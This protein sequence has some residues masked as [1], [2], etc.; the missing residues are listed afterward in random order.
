[1]SL[2]TLPDGA[3]GT[4]PY[5]VGATAWRMLRCASIIVADIALRF[6]CLGLCVFVLH[7]C[8][9]DTCVLRVPE[10]SGEGPTTAES[11]QMR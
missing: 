11:L 1:M 3:M 6:L 5:S 4:F 7:A 8:R 9:R 2:A 10:S